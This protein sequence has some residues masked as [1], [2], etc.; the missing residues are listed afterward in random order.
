M[1]ANRLA[2]NANELS[3]QIGGFQADSHMT[4]NVQKKCKYN[5]HESQFLQLIIAW[6]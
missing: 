1:S 4:Q 6:C 3:A 5:V 2:Q